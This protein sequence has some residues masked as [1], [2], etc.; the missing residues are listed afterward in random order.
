[1]DT[2]DAVVI[3]A[4]HHGLIAA[5]RLADAGWDVT[6]LE[7][8]PEVG[9][10]V[11]SAE[12]T[13]GYITDLFSAFY[14]LAVASPGFADL[15][16][17]AHGLRWSS[18]PGPFGHPNGPADRNAMVVHPDPTK[19]AARLAAYDQR[20]ERAWLDL[21]EQWQTI[22]PQLLGLLFRPFPPVRAVVGLLRATGTASAVRL[23][24]FLLLPANQ[25]V[26]ELFHSDHARLLFL[27]NALHADIPLDAPGSGMMGYLLTMLAQ[28]S[29]FPVPVGGAGELTAALRR[30]CESAGG[31]VV[32]DTRVERIEVRG[33]RA[34]A[35]I[36]A[37]GHRW[38]AARAI[39]ADVSAPALYTRLL[40]ASE[41][42]TRVL[43]D[44]A[45]FEWD[46]PVVKI[47]YALN[48]T[49]PWHSLN[50][51]EAGT[52]HVGVDMQ[53]VAHATADI[54][55]GRIPQHPFLLFGQMTTADPSRSPAGTESAWSYSHLPRGVVDEDSAQTLAE[56]MDQVMED[57]APGFTEQVID[58]HVQ[59][60]ADLHDLDANLVGGAVNG[61]TAQLFQ[62][63]IFRPT[64]GLGGPV[65]P[66]E[67]LFLASASAHPGGGV[68][69]ACGTNAARAALAAA[70]PLGLPRRYLNRKLLHHLMS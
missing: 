6:V 1:M 17:E 31:R 67:G 49:I 70:G 29:G 12:L 65:T 48:G 19:T 15:D 60:P 41:V 46:T 27:G 20:D 57:H 47:N 14:P 38:P 66:V 21:V 16:L 35:V 5:I 43:A 30:R 44:I 56:R 50:L 10:A 54:E 63:L 62:Q 34:S 4:G 64:P 61:G 69:G 58:R 25:M 37:G 13:P 8:Q 68:H 40:P 42:P 52:V 45:D 2:A 33:R 28:D 18:A 24:R 22:R 51:A 3:G 7:A 11:R 32:V 39:L 26:R 59:T 55:S 53:N 9:G 23:A 36:D